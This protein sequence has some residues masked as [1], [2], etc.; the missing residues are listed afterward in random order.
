[1]QGREDLARW[2]Q[3]QDTELFLLAA[4]FSSINFYSSRS[5]NQIHLLTSLV[6]VPTTPITYFKIKTA[7]S[8]PVFDAILDN[9]CLGMDVKSRRLKLPVQPGV[10]LNAISLTVP[11]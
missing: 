10:C 11:L 1:M 9:I 2:S 5:Q 7:L 4:P 3:S 6:C 8:I